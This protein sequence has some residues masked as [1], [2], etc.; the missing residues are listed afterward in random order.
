[1]LTDIS[2]AVFAI[3]TA[4]LA[5]RLPWAVLQNVRQGDRYR[6]GLLDQLKRLPLHEVL[7]RHGIDPTGYL[8]SARM[9]DVSRH[10]RRCGMCREQESCAAQLRTG[11]DMSGFH[12]CPN[13]AEL[14]PGTEQPSAQRPDGEADAA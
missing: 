9:A 14:A 11:A 3:L 4:V 7:Q 6:R 13:H 1:M 12:F 10:M 5:I 8:H 2:I